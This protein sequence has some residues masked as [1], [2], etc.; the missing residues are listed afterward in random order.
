M[1]TT[2]PSQNLHSVPYAKKSMEKLIQKWHGFDNNR[3]RYCVT[4]RFALSCS[5]EMLT[6]A[7]QISAHYDLWMQT[8][9][10]ENREEVQIA[11]NLFPGIESYLD[12][13]NQFGLLHE[14]SLFAHCIYVED[15]DGFICDKAVVSHN[16][17]SNFF[18][19]P[20]IC[21]Y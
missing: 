18:L 8:H 2:A 15:E 3:L 14:K 5:S 10:S 7:G 12:I 4:P 21:I 11:K 6:M 17:D 1:D 19:V 16:P 9:L 13:Y 20:A